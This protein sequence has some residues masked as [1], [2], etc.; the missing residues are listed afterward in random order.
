MLRKLSV[1]AVSLIG[2]LSIPALA[3]ANTNPTYTVK[4]GDTLSKIAKSEGVSVQNLVSLNHIKNAN[5]IEIGQVIRFKKATV[6]KAKAHSFKAATSPATVANSVA[7]TAEKYIG[8]PYAWGGESPA[9]FDCS[10]FTQYVF[11]KVGVDL[12]RQSIQQWTIGSAVS[13]NQLQKGDLV[14][15]ADTY[16]SGVSHLG[17]Y[18]G[19]DK[20]IE[21]SSSKGVTIS[22]LFSNPYWS[23]HYYGARSILN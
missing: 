7:A 15:F 13:K 18:L 3:L 12:P 1:L 17:I 16:R 2:T 20:F 9:G 4:R 6:S 8:T 22:N 19:N 10:G 11:R 21:A 5:Y 23:Q 14:F